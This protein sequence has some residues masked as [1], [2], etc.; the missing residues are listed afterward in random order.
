MMTAMTISASPAPSDSRMDAVRSRDKAADGAFFFA[1]TTTG[2]Y[3]R[4]SCP[5]RTP[6]PENVRFYATPEAARGAGFRACLRCRPDQ[7]LGSAQAAMIA[8]A[9]R[10]IETAGSEPTLEQLARTAGLSPFHFH[11]VFKSVTGLTPKAYATAHRTR[12]VRQEL[13]GDGRVTDA[14]Y[15]AGFG[16]NG[17]F[18]A[19][20]N[21]ILGM[22]PKRFRAGGADT[23][24]RFAAAQCSLGAILVAE[25]DKGICAVSLGDDPDELVRALQD[26]FPKALLVGG[27]AAF[28]Q[29]VA[30][31]VGLVERPGEGADLPLDIRGT[32]FQQKV[33]AAL[34][35][36]PPGRTLSY[37]ELA[38]EIGDAKAVR[39]VAGACAANT[40]AVL[41][42]CHRIVRTDGSLSGYR[43]GVERKRAL[44]DRE[45]A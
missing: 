43:W 44:L 5:A 19:A 34:R 8:T 24:I 41:V 17:R 21:A 2:V 22:T 4:P 33:W 36:I 37:A 25:S 18:Y 31:V 15:D 9:C 39:A 1:V 27:D 13:T 29:R 3:C 20:S 10:Q 32:A 11:R 45:R 14:I 30:Q 6:K 23:E 35:R 16:S 26:R 42:P 12:K 40:L 7:P 38:S 28:E